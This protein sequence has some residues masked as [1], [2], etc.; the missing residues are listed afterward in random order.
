MNLTAEIGRRGE[1]IAAQYLLDAGFDLLHRNWRSGRYEIDIAAVK[2]GMLH[3][4]EVKSRS[5]GGY[6][7]PEEAMTA[8]KF[9]SL[10]KAAELYIS[11]YG[12][13]MDVQFDLI[14]VTYH[15]QGAA[16]VT[17]YP[18]VVYPRW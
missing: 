13:D 1:D 4:V 6:S 12:L 2:D 3:I 9:R 8:H 17:Y 5:D 18:E 14:A 15:G 16:E 11:S 7:T 10:V